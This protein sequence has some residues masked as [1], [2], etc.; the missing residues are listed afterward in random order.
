MQISVTLQE[1]MQYSLFPVVLLTVLLIGCIG[2]W[3]YVWRK[4][5][6][7]KNKKTD[8]AEALQNEE[9]PFQTESQKQALKKKYLQYLD[10][11]ER[12]LQNGEI[13]QRKAYQK[14]SRLIRQ[15][16][17]GMTGKKVQ[18]YTLQEI[19]REHFTELAKLMEEYEIPEFSM[20]ETGNF[21]ISVEKTKRVIETWK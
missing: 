9:I 19:K 5:H 2:V 20:L 8:T 12:K 1:P 7:A 6:P 4:K 17:Y 18:Y 10:E 3:C 13:T 15:F 16:V 14:T 21:K 11:V